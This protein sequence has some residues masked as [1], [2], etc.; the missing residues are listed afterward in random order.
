MYYRHH[1]TAFEPR[2]TTKT[3][4]GPYVSD[5]DGVFLDQFR[6]VTASQ[7]FQSIIVSI[8][9]GTAR[10]RFESIMYNHHHTSAFDLRVVTISAE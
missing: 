4:E 6:N 1:T 7:P 3:V 5:Q 10:L 8:M 9:N 2:V